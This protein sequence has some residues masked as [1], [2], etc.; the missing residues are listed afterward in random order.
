MPATLNPTTT[1]F[2]SCLTVAQLRQMVRAC[3]LKGL[4]TA[5][6]A[7]L[8]HVLAGVID[9]EHEIAADMM[10]R[11]AEEIRI[12]KALAEHPTAHL[13]IISPFGKVVAETVESSPIDSL[14]IAIDAME[15]M[16]A[17]AWNVFTRNRDAQT[18]DTV[19][20]DVA[21]QVWEDFDKAISGMRQTLAMFNGHDCDFWQ[22]EIGLSNCRYGCKIYRCSKCGD[23]EKVLH[24]ATYGCKG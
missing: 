20:I 11:E 23:D 24:N 17:K 16:R 13:P 1:E 8:V 14:K 7:N 5:R 19:A 3:K 18:P 15:P 21:Y 12:E 9:I 22:T 2:L 4:S 10:A 6:K